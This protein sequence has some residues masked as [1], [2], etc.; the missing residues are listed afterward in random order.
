MKQ[1][2]FIYYYLLYLNNVKFLFLTIEY[3]N[4][5]FSIFTCFPTTNLKKIL[6]F[7]I[8]NKFFILKLL[9]EYQAPMRE[10]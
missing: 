5:N 10:K 4:F 1:K 8:T 7:V 3:G 9:V 6:F 2:P